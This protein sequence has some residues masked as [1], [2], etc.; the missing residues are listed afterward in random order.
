MALNCPNTELQLVV[1]SATC[2]DNRA[3][4]LHQ[5]EEATTQGGS[6]AYYIDDEF[7]LRAR[8]RASAAVY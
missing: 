7:V 3:I 6:I 1:S 4:C 2:N 8:E 5:L